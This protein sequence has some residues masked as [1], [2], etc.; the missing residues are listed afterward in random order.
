MDHKDRNR[1]QGD[2]R[3]TKR[4]EENLDLLILTSLA[5]Y[6]RSIHKI[7]VQEDFVK[8]LEFVAENRPIIRFMKSGLRAMDIHFHPSLVHVRSY[9]AIQ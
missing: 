7:L 8:V 4:K 5:M 9:M 2:S 1:D 6:T 3:M